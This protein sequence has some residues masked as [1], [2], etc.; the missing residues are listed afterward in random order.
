MEDVNFDVPP[1]QK[2]IVRVNDA[3]VLHVAFVTG[4]GDPSSVFSHGR[5]EPPNI[6]REHRQLRAAFLDPNGELLSA[7]GAQH[8]PRR[9]EPASVVETS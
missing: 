6:V 7:T 3:V 5:S 4:L 8:H 1:G 9:V 2:L